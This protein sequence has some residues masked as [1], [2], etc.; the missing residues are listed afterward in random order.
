MSIAIIYES[1]EWSN[2]YLKDY[3]SKKGFDVLFINFE[4]SVF[5]AAFFSSVQLIVNK[6]V[7]QGTC[8]DILQGY[9]LFKEIK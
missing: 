2:I 8:K 3:L 1:E 7:F 4:K 9:R 6:L 5:D